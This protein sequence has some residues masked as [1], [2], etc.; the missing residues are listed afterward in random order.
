MNKR[1]IDNMLCNYKFKWFCLLPLLFSWADLAAQ[2]EDDEEIYELSPF[3]VQPSSG[4]V[5]QRTL[6][7][8]RLNSE[9]IDVP[10]QISVLTREFLD[11]IAATSPQDAM[12]YSL[13]VENLD[14]F[15][16][17]AGSNFNRGINF[18]NFSGRVRGVSDAGRMRDFFETNLQGDT[19]NLEQITVSS[20]PNAVI[21]GLGGTGGI[22]NTSFKRALVGNDAYTMEVRGDSEGSIRSTLDVNKVLI[23]DRLAI[24][25][26]G[27]W[28]DFNTYR[29]SSAGEQDRYFFTLTARPWNGAN[30]QAYYEDV[31]IRKSLPRNVVAYDGGVTAY[32]EHVAAGGDRFY[33]NSQGTAILP[34]W[35]GLVQKYNN[36]RD[37]WVLQP[38]N[39]VTN[40]GPASGAGLNSVRTIDPSSQ[41]PQPSDRFRWSLPM[42]SPLVSLEHNLHG[43]TSGRHMYGDIKGLIFS[44]SITEDLAVEVGYNSESGFTDFWNMAQPSAAVVRVD[45][46][47]F[48]PDGETPN[49]WR[50]YMYVDH[51]G[52]STTDYNEMAGFRSTVSYNLD[53][54]D[55]SKW[56]GRHNIMALYTDDYYDRFWSWMRSRTIPADRVGS[57]VFN[58]GSGR[59]QGQ[60]MYRWYID[61]KTYEMVNPFD[62][63]EGGPQPDGTFVFARGNAPAA[64]FTWSSLNKR[65]GATAAIQSFWWD[66]RLVTTLGYRYG[67]FQSGRATVDVLRNT[68][69]VQ[70]GFQN[71]RDVDRSKDSYGDETT[72][73]AINYGAV[74]HLTEEDSSFGAWSLFYNF[75]DI[76]NS[77][78]PSHYPDDRG[79]PA[80]IGESY[81]FGIIWSGF[82]SR[83]GARVNFYNTESANVNN[84]GW[85]QQIRNRVVNIERRIGSPG[86]EVSQ[87]ENPYNELLDAGRITDGDGN[88]LSA[89][90][91]FNSSTFAVGQVLSYWHMTADRTSEGLEIEA[92]ANPTENLTFR[93]TAANNEATDVNGLKGWDTWINDRYDY[94][95]SWA[96]W[97]QNAYL[98]EGTQPLS[99]GGGSVTNQFNILAPAYVTIS[100]SDGVRVN[101]NAG[102]RMNLIGRYTFREGFMKGANLGAIYRFREAPVI[103]YLSLP[104]DTPFSSWPGQPAQFTAPSLS[105]PVVAPNRKDFDLFGSYRGKLTDNMDYYVRLNIRNA[106]NDTDVI[107]Q[108][109]RTDGSIAVYT[110]KPPR[111]YILSVGLTF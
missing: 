20:G 108:R 76:F 22:I 107:P 96:R 29:N 47:L 34:G 11:D 35:E 52:Q 97:E 18:N 81:D 109:A 55:V 87:A 88:P 100:N 28:D 103:G 33:D 68:P 86:V 73:D 90:V 58:A 45:P 99:E 71:I 77:P 2:D 79:I 26:I 21:Y 70:W 10:Q 9:L 14:E 17:P 104:S 7:G 15:S 23:E 39:T 98:D 27:L 56:L 57:Y 38:N 1:L 64:G 62:P 50:G 8:T 53:L 46:N 24:R 43:L 41:A 19:Y 101:Q 32:M 80:A 63:L 36:N 31:N 48:L 105:D 60:T 40:I 54:T 106:F 65:E 85:C 37:H 67:W 49:P 3:E 93:F 91:P 61:P 83:I 78:T 75:A 72:E 4:Y 5:A 95:L 94:W 111:T 25:I 92:W 66:D 102:W 69:D 84:C 16:D 89:P 42:D 59:G 74:L 51:W 6:S 13:N 44:Q 30:I 82:D 110:F 12:L